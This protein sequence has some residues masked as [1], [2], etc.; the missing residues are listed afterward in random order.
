M[1]PT[2][3]KNVKDGAL[4]RIDCFPMTNLRTRSGQTADAGENLDP[5]LGSG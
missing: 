4:P 1:V 2:F 5:S 3:A